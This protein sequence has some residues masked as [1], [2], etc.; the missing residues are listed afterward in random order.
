MKTVSISELQKSLKKNFSSQF[1]FVY[2]LS[3]NKK[4][5]GIA[6]PDFVSFLEDEGILEM[7]ED[8][9]LLKD[10]EL[11]KRQKRAEKIITFGDYSETLSFD[12]L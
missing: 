1:G 7:Y 10:P 8:Y 3:N 6:T 2:V 5:G 4:A 11:E 12:E 9:L